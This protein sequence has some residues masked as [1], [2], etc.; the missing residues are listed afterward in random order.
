M[1]TLPLLPDTNIRNYLFMGIDYRSANCHNVIAHFLN[2][3][4]FL[5]TSKLFRLGHSEQTVFC[6]L[7]HLHSSVYGL[8][9]A[10]FFQFPP[11]SLWGS[12][13]PAVW[14]SAFFQVKPQQQGKGSLVI[15]LHQE[16]KVTEFIMLIFL[17]GVLSWISFHCSEYL[18]IF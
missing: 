10:K 11:V 3:R 6:P 17:N 5:G 8:R 13:R 16:R 7:S 14:C 1:K 15:S 9:L 12:E 4:G 2:A 18:S